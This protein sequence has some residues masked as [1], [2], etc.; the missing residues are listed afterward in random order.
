MN[1]MLTRLPDGTVNAEPGDAVEFVYGSE[2]RPAIY[3]GLLP[4]NTNTIDIA[5]LRLPGADNDFPTALAHVRHA[6]GGAGHLR[7][8]VTRLREAVEGAMTNAK[9]METSTAKP[10]SLQGTD[11]FPAVVY[12][13]MRNV[14]ADIDSYQFEEPQP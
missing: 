12:T 8:Q 14:L 4:Q 10:N 9:R 1:V 5:V 7:L 2:W 3:R 6:R 11:Y 13:A